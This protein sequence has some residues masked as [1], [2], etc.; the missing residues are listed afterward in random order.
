MAPLAGSH[1]FG[2]HLDLA[3]YLA[4]AWTGEPAGEALSV[5]CPTSTDLSLRMQGK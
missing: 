3:V 1:C 4:H 5:G 2:F